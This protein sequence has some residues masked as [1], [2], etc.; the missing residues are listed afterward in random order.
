MARLVTLRLRHQDDPTG[1]YAEALVNPRHVV[2]VEEWD[3]EDC[4][5]MLVTGENVLARGDLGDVASAL[6]GDDD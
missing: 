3:D 4:R 1:T 2:V 5:L 6:A